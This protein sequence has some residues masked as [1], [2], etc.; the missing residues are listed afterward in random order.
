MYYLNE[1]AL[2]VEV[3]KAKSFTRAAENL[4]MPK[5]TLS[6]KISELEQHLGIKLLNRTTRKIELTESGAF[7]YQ[8]ALRLVEEI[9]FTHQQLQ[10]MRSKP[11]GKL[12]ISSPMDFTYE[13]ITPELPEFCAEYPDIHFEFDITPRRVDLIS[14]PFDLAIRTGE[15]PDSNLISQLLIKIPRYL[16]AAPSYLSQYGEPNSPAELAQHRCI[17]LTQSSQHGWLL[18][19]QQQEIIFPV[20][21]QMVMNNMGMS[22]RLAKLGMGI[23]LAP[24]GLARQT[25]LDGKLKRILPQWQSSPVPVYIL[26]TSRLISAKTQCFIDFLKIKLAQW[27]FP[28]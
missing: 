23:I 17:R 15:L 1:M 28:K 21:D 8:N 27:D 5:S 14:E 10:N 9:R 3:V 7:Y 24:E 12:R 19:N 25:V 11:Q 22:L 13:F 16:Y 6:N 26:T 4:S 18:K 20:D 2:F